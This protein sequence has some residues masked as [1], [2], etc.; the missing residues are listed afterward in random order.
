MGMANSSHRVRVGDI[1][2]A[3]RIAGRGKPVI[4]V[5]GL[6]CGQ[7]MWFTSGDDCPIVTRSSL[8]TNA[9]T[10]KAMPRMTAVIR[11]RILR[12][13]CRHHRYARLRQDRSRRL[14]HGRRSG[15]RTCG[16]QTRADYASRSRRR[17]I[18]RG[19]RV[20]NPMVGS[21][22]GRFCRAHRLGRV[23]PGHAAKRFF[24]I[25]C[26]SRPALSSPYGGPD[27]RNTAYWIATYPLASAGPA[28]IAFPHAQHV[29]SHQGP[30]ARHAGPVRLHLPERCPAL[31]GEY[32]TRRPSQNRS[33]RT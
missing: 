4:L 30:H 29:A 33:G 6:A 19:R 25:I 27:S 17:R 16:G 9:G 8:T 3:Y 5:H 10:A 11:A 32:P 14:F 15:T 26:Q 31:V 20:A 2:L 28:Q 21:A 22:V 12:A 7:R 1:E 13:I 23:A 18:G 24:Q